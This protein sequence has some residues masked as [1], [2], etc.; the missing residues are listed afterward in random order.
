MCF[1]ATLFGETDPVLGYDIG[2]FIFQKPFIEL[3]IMYF[4]VAIVALS[5]YSAI[6]YIASFNIYF[7]GIDRQTLRKKCNIETI[8]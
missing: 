3:V 6:Y 1:N 2:Y 8:N 4:L 7:E 5:I